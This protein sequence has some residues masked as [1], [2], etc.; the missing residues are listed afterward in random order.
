MA[1]F[2]T[3]SLLAHLGYDSDDNNAQATYTNKH[4]L[5]SL[6]YAQ[7]KM[8]GSIFVLAVSATAVEVSTNRFNF[9]TEPS[10]VRE[11]LNALYPVWRTS[12]LEPVI[13]EQTPMT[14]EQPVIM[15]Q[16]QPMQQPMQQPVMKQQPVIAQQPLTVQQPAMV[17]EQSTMVERKQ[18]MVVE[19]ETVIMEQ[20]PLM[21]EQP[22]MV[23][24]HQPMVLMQQPMM[25]E[26]QILMVQEPMMMEQKPLF[27]T[28]TTVPVRTVLVHP[29]SAPLFRTV[30]LQQPV[31]RYV[32]DEE[33]P[34]RHSTLLS[35]SDIEVCALAPA[36]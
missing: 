28:R 6:F 4:N 7:M 9:R 20:Q 31:L 33:T 10:Y 3:R 12:L 25:V 27:R 8:I 13:V 30:E 1:S 16:Q 5:A 18:P 35:K 24:K 14:V 26:Q 29:S 19:E 17:V 21:V 11:Q 2:P 36:S 32:I 15:Q 22:T 34:A 23:E